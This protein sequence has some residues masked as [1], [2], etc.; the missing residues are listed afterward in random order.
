MQ[1]HQHSSQIFIPETGGTY[2]Y[3]RKVLGNKASLLAGISFITGKVISS[4][5]IAL[6]FGNYLFP[7]SH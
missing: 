2:L 4:I 5:A 3:A 1:A 6:T 7:S